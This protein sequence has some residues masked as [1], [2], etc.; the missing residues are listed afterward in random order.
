M[1][2]LQIF[3]NIIAF[4]EEMHSPLELCEIFTRT[5]LLDLF[6]SLGREVGINKG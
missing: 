3:L 2:D 6:F 1:L 5:K 4:F